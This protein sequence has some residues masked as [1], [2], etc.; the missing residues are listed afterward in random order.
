MTP[1]LQGTQ[2]VELQTAATVEAFRRLADLRRG[3]PLE[4]AS[5]FALAWMVGARMF[6]LGMVREGSRIIALS[7]PDA[8]PEA[9]SAIGTLCAEIIWT[10]ASPTLNVDTEVSQAVSI[11]GQL[12]D[13]APDFYLS[14]PDVIWHLPTARNADSYVLAPEAC[15]LMFSILGAEPGA[16]VWLPF[17]PVG[18]LAARAMRLGLAVELGGPH[19]WASDVQQ[20]FLAVLGMFGNE[21]R[22]DAEAPTRPDGKRDF[23]ADYLIAMPP[24]AA[25]VPTQLGWNR[26]EDIDE[27]LARIPMLVQSIGGMLQL[28]LD[29]TDAWTPAALWPRVKKRAVFMAAQS[30]LFARGQ[31]QRL[32]EAW[33]HGGYPIDMVL[34]LPGRMNTSASIAPS[35]L[36]FDQRASGRAMTMADFS[37]FTVRSGGAGGRSSKTLDLQRSLET[38]AFAGPTEP[39]SQ[40]GHDS[41]G[42]INPGTNEALS[43]FVR[44]VPFGELRAADCNLQP[45]RYLQAPI[46]L[47]GDR[48]PLSELVE[49]IRAPVPNT[50]PAAVPA[51]EIGIPDLGGWRAVKPKAPTATNSVRVVQVRDRRLT[52]A[53]L[54]RGDIVMSIKGT[55]GRTVLIGESAVHA[56]S[57]TEG[58]TTWSLVTSGNCIALRP[59]GGE[60]TSEYLMLYFRSKEFERQCEALLVGAVIPH[61]TPDALR[62]SVQVPMPSPSEL[63]QAHDRYR[64]LCDLEAQADTVNAQIAAIVGGLW[65]LQL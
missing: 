64:R 60:V 63:A 8:W 55:V 61:V 57:N 36:V 29:R 1:Q 59:I 12:L 51:I 14:V 47:A 50:D 2:E 40:G 24:I 22:A 35:L 58:A 37:D 9:H 6:Q 3:S 52:T 20:L 10:K 19:A 15:D 62:D 53:A 41:P 32:R 7:E 21:A 26:W 65:P 18:Q 54:R 48:K 27:N 45:S 34:S 39:S 44:Q 25:R 16:M 42:A 4:D 11:I 30:L 56:D 17:D 33:I 5:K 43:T 38:L 46:N 31:E 49:V 23:T 13:Q 28:R